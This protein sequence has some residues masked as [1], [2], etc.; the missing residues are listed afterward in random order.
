M[1]LLFKD[2]LATLFHQL[3]S[4]WSIVVKLT[5]QLGLNLDPLHITNLS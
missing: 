4:L 3:S 2:H 1:T 5:Y